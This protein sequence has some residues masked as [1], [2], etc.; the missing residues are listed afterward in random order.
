MLQPD[1]AV[2]GDGAVGLGREVPVGGSGVAV[3]PRR[4]VQHGAAGAHP[5][6][7]VGQPRDDDAV[8]AVAAVVVRGGQDGESEDAADGVDHRGQ[9]AV[10]QGQLVEHRGGQRQRGGRTHDD[11]LVGPGVEAVLGAE[12][13]VG[14]VAGEHVVEPS[15]AQRVDGVGVAGRDALG[16]QLQHRVD[17]GVAADHRVDVRPA[18]QHD[19]GEV[20]GQ[21]LG[22]RIGGGAER[23]PA[24]RGGGDGVDRFAGVEQYVDLL[25]EGAVG[26]A[27]GDAV[28]HDDT[29]QVGVL[30]VGALA[31]VVRA[32][33]GGEPA[34]GGVPGQGELLLELLDIAGVAGGQCAVD[35]D[36]AIGVEERRRGRF[37]GGGAHQAPAGEGEGDGRQ[38]G[39]DHDAVGLHRQVGGQGRVEAVDGAEAVLQP[40]HALG[41]DGAVG[42]GREVPV[43]GD[44]V[45]EERARDVEAGVAD[46]HT[47]DTVGVPGSDRVGGDDGGGAGDGDRFGALPLGGGH[48]DDRGDGRRGGSR[49]PAEAQRVERTD[50]Q[51]RGR[52]DIGGFGGACFG[53]AGIAGHSEHRGRR[54]GGDRRGRRC[55][56]SVGADRPAALRSGRRH[57]DAGPGGRGISG[58]RGRCG[59][60]LFGQRSLGGGAFATATDSG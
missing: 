55:G 59:N 4:D 26:R 35:Q 12:R 39:C 51:C 40:D 15:G 37:L 56:F 44:G 3:L 32:H 8:Q 48:R 34:A 58:G 30:Q 2:G 49:S 38:R 42:L 13:A 21:R 53:G 19:A 24:L 6:H 14:G 46:L 57:G 10:A 31:D 45:A 9:D 22:E 27:V 54:C 33:R 5:G 43:G 16:D 52:G 7:P 17:D 18:G 29:D 20:A 1:H 47:G 60:R 41:V 36:G 23:I 28:E 11:R 50:Q 25:G